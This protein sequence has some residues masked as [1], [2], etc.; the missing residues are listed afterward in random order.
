MQPRM[1]SLHLNH[2]MLIMVEGTFDP[3]ISVVTWFL[4][5]R[6]LH[7]QTGEPAPV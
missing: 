6:A 2:D 3:V 5:E 4:R 7:I 1:F